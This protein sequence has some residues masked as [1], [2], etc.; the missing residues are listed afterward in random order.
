MSENQRAVVQGQEG[1]R[2]CRV[3]TQVPPLPNTT[4]VKHLLLRMTPP[5]ALPSSCP[6]CPL[7]WRLISRPH[8]PALSSVPLGLDHFPFLCWSSHL[9]PWAQS[10]AGPLCHRHS[11][12]LEF[13]TLHS[14]VGWSVTKDW[15]SQASFVLHVTSLP[16]TRYLSFAIRF[17]SSSSRKADSKC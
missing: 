13:A 5:A 6:Y 15:S 8:L 4:P 9:S 3:K 11:L 17:S 10:Q 7:T 1:G 14:L 16:P 2:A 12:G